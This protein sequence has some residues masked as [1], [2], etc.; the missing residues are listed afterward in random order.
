MGLIQSDGF[1]WDRLRDYF[2]F[3]DVGLSEGEY[4]T[5]LEAC[6]KS[7]KGKGDRATL[8]NLLDVQ[9]S[10]FLEQCWVQGGKREEGC[11]SPFSIATERA[12]GFLQINSSM[13][14]RYVGV[15]RDGELLSDFKP[16]EMIRD[17]LLPK[18][19]CSSPKGS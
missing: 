9:A 15:S 4:G 17:R 11:R 13:R 1:V 18:R 2:P 14:W 8:L 12:S 19:A 10:V 6:L 7:L 3:G 16:D 5:V